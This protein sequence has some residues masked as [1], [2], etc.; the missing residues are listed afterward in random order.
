[1]YLINVKGAVYIVTTVLQRV[2]LPNRYY[3]EIAMYAVKAHGN[4]DMSCAVQDA[5][6]GHK[7]LGLAL[8]APDLIFIAA[9]WSQVKQSGNWE[10]GWSDP[11]NEWSGRKR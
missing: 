4:K 7:K 10:T 9:A 1:M 8:S 2:K 5:T 6:R 3:K 11:D